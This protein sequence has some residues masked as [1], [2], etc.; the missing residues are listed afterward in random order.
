MAA[1]ARQRHHA[2]ERLR[3]LEVENSELSA[4]LEHERRMRAAE[5]NAAERAQLDAER[6][7]RAE[8]EAA[9]AHEKARRDRR[10]QSPSP[11]VSW[12]R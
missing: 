6:A 8:R 4:A 3:Q 1:V 11:A 9:Q 2:A 5:V 10:R 12:G 7:K